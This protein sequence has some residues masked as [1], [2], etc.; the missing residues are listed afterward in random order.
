MNGGTY[1]IVVIGI[2]LAKA[3]GFVRNI[4]FASTFGADT[5]TDIYSQVFG[6][7]TY[8]FCGIGTALGTLVIKNMNKA[9]NQGAEQQRRYVSHFILKISGIVTAATALMYALGGP[10]VRILLPGLDPAYFDAA[11]EMLYIMLPSGLFVIVAYIMSGVLQNCKVFF[12]TSIVS[13]PYNVIII[14]S[15]IFG[16]PDMTA[17]CWI[18][19]LGWFLHLVILLPDFYRKG[20]RFFYRSK[21]EK[22]PLAKERNMEVLYI[23]I[24]SMMFQMCYVFDKAAVSHDS[25]AA[26]TINYATNLFVTIA[27]IFVVAMSNV[28]FP[29]ISRNYEAGNTGAVKKTTQQLIA[30]LFAIIVPFILVVACFGTD[31]IALVYQRGEF[32]AELTRETAV[33]FIIYT[34]GIFGYVCQELFNKILYLGSRYRYP[35]IGSL[36]IMALKP[37]INLV[38]IRWGSVAV[39]LSTTLLFLVYAILIGWAITKVTGNYLSKELLINLAKIFGAGLAA[40]AVFLGWKLSGIQLPLGQ[41][42]F[43]LIL[44]LCAV[45][46]LAVIW[47]TGLVKVLLPKE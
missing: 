23:F 21:G 39:A 3:L 38:V 28:C 32:T 26:T 36:V 29:S 16:N 44:G 4:F 6:I 33:L 42:G 41:L 40:L 8:V 19:T 1:L 15:M 25:G 10:I 18:T 14:G 31:V 43:V 12:I 35:V 17:M 22:A 7:A 34:L 37:L 30:L 20:F 47:F 13:L 46:Y 2:L 24:S 11:R 27:S 45:V 5:L 9:E